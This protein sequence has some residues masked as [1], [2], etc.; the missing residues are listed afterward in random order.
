MYLGGAFNGTRLNKIYKESLNEEEIL[1]E[2][3]PILER[4]AKERRREE[5]FGDFVIRVGIVK[6]TK[7]G[8]DFHE[9]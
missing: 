9:L 2:L 3:D 4:Y 8:R 7:N 5:H 1:T 6:E